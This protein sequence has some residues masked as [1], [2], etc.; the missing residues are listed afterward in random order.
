MF[1]PAKMT[2]V[3]ALVYDTD[4]ENVTAEILRLGILQLSDATESK[5]WAKDMASVANDEMVEKYA[6]H[7]DRIRSIAA[8]L[9]KPIEIKPE[10]TSLGK[11]NLPA[12][13]ENLDKID[14]E[15]DAYITKKRFARQE[16]GRLMSLLTE[17]KGAIGAGLPIGV[18]GPFSFLEAK[19][20]RISSKNVPILHSLLKGIPSVVL[21]T[22]TSGDKVDCLIMVL[23]KDR[24]V[25]D[26]A[27]KQISFNLIELAQ[28]RGEETDP[29]FT[30]EIREKILKEEK[31][32]DNANR[33]LDRIAAE[34]MPALS[35]SLNLVHAHKVLHQAESH[36]KRTD[37]TYLISGWVPAS[38]K[39]RLISRIQSLTKNKCYVEDI[40]AEELG[41]KVEVPVMFQ[42]PGFLKP[43]EMLTG[44][45]GLPRYNTIDPTLFLALSFVVMFGAMFGDVGHGGVLALLG[46]FAVLKKSLSEDIRKMGLL[47][48]YTGVS[49]IIFGFVYGS[50]FGPSDLSHLLHYEGFEPM[51]NIQ[52]FFKVAIYFGIGFLSLGILLNIINSVRTK[53]FFSGVFGKEGLLGGVIYWIGIILVA[54][55]LSK[56][57]IG[58][59][60]YLLLLLLVG[61]MVVF[62]LR[63]PIKKILHPHEPMFHEGFFMYIM[64][65]GIELIEIFAG[66]LSNTMS[67]IR[68]AAFALAHGGLFISVYAIAGVA[69]TYGGWILQITLNSGIIVLEGLIVSIQAVRLE[70]YEFFGKFY[71]TGSRGY[72][73]SNMIEVK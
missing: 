25:L 68:V 28:K 29:H 27:L 23:R 31:D 21:Q 50:F 38:R 4:V 2:N 17:T 32:L 71:R 14:E 20:V 55:L 52:F 16:I 5:E 42:N 63:A 44:G 24:R 43:F 40:S 51:K 7:E 18:E 65:S 66:Y 69:G 57:S 35:E 8:K 60:P 45:Y 34:K 56:G 13:A 48:L 9:G 1:L 67:F 47:L 33:E 39:E 58:L 61:P 53:E 37:R 73:P 72:K 6:K 62:F 15:S 12:L 30:E 26:E 19:A 22:G 46:L 10:K 36:F 11:L 59:N 70:Y 54:R 64:E 3:T 49:A 41:A